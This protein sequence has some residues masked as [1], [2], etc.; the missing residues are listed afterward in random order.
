VNLTIFSLVLFTVVGVASF[1]ASL[2]A[3]LDQTVLAQSGGYT[4][5]GTSATPI[6]DLPAKVAANATLAREFV[7]V[8]PVVAG[9]TE[10]RLPGTAKPWPDGLFAAPA[11]ATPSANFYTTNRFNFTDTLDGL[12]ATQVWARLATDPSVA[13]VDH[14]YA[15]SNFGGFGGPS[16]PTV[17]VG[18]AVGVLNPITG[19]SRTVTILGIMNQDFVSGIWLSPAG[20]QALGYVEQTSYFFGIAPGVSATHAAQSAKIAFFPYGLTL[21]DFQ[22][23]LQTSIASTEAIIGL[24]EIFVALGLGVGIA[25]MGIVA[26]RAVVER[27]AE[28]GML[29]AMGFRRG[30]VLRVFFL[31]YSYVALLGIGIG[32]ALGILVVYNAVLGTQ[33]LLAFA[34]PWVNVGIILAVS[35]V[36]TVAA[37]AGP[38]VRASRLPPAEAIRYS[39]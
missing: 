27:R 9:A 23:A 28:I 3:D 13:V 1:G 7:H 2:Q 25:A 39:E 31:E 22:Q 10:L 11:N 17:K 20:A 29:R 33:G 37:I 26:L 18:D 35:Y 8:V 6:P 19:A 12:S 14:A 32:A 21:V 16:H 36:L 30:G 24:L 15:G 4:F 5:F 38:S 34:I